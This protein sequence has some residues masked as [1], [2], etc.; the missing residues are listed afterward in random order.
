[1]YFFN[2]SISSVLRIHWYAKY[3][4]C[5]QRQNRQI[6][7]SLVL[8]NDLVKQVMSSASAGSGCSSS[9]SWYTPCCQ[10]GDFLTKF[11]DFLD[12]LSNFLPQKPL[13]TNV[14]TL[15]GVSGDFSRVLETLTWQVLPSAPHHLTHGQLQT[16]PWPL[17]PHCKGN[18]HTHSCRTTQTPCPLCV[19]LCFSLKVL[20][21]SSSYLSWNCTLTYR[22][23]W[24]CILHVL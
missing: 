18:V 9:Q 3:Q 24:Q 22:K 6:G 12:P 1:M 17:G 10:L 4:I 15:S 23:E 20:L 16:G 8:K 2:F 14:A 13:A 11:N 19:S 21:A 7:A 5:Y